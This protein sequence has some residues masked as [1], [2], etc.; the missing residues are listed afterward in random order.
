MN[1]LMVGDVFG[2]S[3]RAAAVKLI[4]RLRQ[5][6]AIDMCVAQ[7]RERRRRLRRHAADVPSVPG[8]RAPT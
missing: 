2:E 6:H 4:P 1:V 8:G 3:G 7:R 5:E